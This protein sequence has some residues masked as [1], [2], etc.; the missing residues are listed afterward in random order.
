MTPERNGFWLLEANNKLVEIAGNGKLVGKDRRRVLDVQSS[1]ALKR[2]IFEQVTIWPSE[3]EGLNALFP[4][5]D[6]PVIFPI[7]SKRSALGILILDPEQHA[8]V[9]LYQFIS[10]FAAMIIH[11]SQLHKKVKEQREELDEMT[12]IL[13]RQNAQLSSLYHVEMDLMKETEPGKLC[14]IVVEAIVKDLEAKR[15]A[16]FLY[17]QDAGAFFAAAEYGG[18]EGIVGNRYALDEIEALEKCLKTGRIITQTD[19]GEA[20]EIG[21]NRLDGWIVLG[22]KGREF[23]QGVMVVELDDEDIG[24]SISILTNYLGILLDNIVLQQKV[25]EDHPAVGD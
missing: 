9:E 14:G 12:G 5:Y 7:K 4:D 6:S 19:F 17:E 15:A 20:I 10:Q 21:A 3:F 13:F 16:A 8:E 2:V 22:L 11:N 23:S 1:E 18:L 25:K 24:D